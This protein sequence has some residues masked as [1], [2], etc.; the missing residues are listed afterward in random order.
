MFHK[1]LLAAVALAAAT[2]L[3]V[4]NNQAQAGILNQSPPT[5][6]DLAN[7]AIDQ[8]YPL[9][10]RAD[11]LSSMMYENCSPRVLLETINQAPL[12]GEIAPYITNFCTALKADHDYFQVVLQDQD[13]VAVGVQRALKEMKFYTTISARLYYTDIK[14]EFLACPW[15]K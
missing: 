11:A 8:K 13:K 15:A 9:F 5:C 7:M 3:S 12:E 2:V 14:A 4:T 6:A 10:S 1:T